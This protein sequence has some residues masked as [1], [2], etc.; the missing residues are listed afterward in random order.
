MN[1]ANV[2]QIAECMGVSKRTIQKRA[3]REKWPFDEYPVRGGMQRMYAIECLPEDVTIRLSRSFAVKA[4][5]KNGPSTIAQDE[6]TTT[7]I[8]RELSE[9]EFA[10][11]VAKYALLQ[12]ALRF[13]RASNTGKVEAIDEFV[14]RYTLHKVPVDDAVYREIPQ[15]SRASLLRWEKRFEYSGLLGL[16]DGFNVK[17]RRYDAHIKQALQQRFGELLTASPTCSVN[18]AFSY[19]SAIYPVSL[20]PSARQWEKLREQLLENILAASEDNAEQ[21]IWEMFVFP[22]GLRFTDVENVAIMITELQTGRHFFALVET[23]NIQVCDA[24]LRKALLHWNKPEG[25]KIVSGLLPVSYTSQALLRALGIRCWSNNRRYPMSQR[26]VELV[27]YL[28]FCL[29]QSVGSDDVQS[30]MNRVLFDLLQMTDVNR[31]QPTIIADKEDEQR[32]GEHINMP[33][34]DLPYVADEMHEKIAAQRSREDRVVAEPFAKD[35]FLEESS[36]AQS[37]QVSVRMLD[38]LLAALPEHG[39]LVKV[40]VHGITFENRLFTADWLVDYVGHVV[41]CRWDPIMTNQL[42]VFTALTKRFIGTV[43]YVKS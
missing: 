19:L 32:L 15:V 9:A 6:T 14:A 7:D 13:A 11:C 24:L 18:Q 25:V 33:M 30:L 31:H 35:C 38:G 16:L 4:G 12:A 42:F 37:W 8:E 21:P 22:V 39:G 29:C 27:R 36:P 10:R 3:L 1:Q 28:L 2:I 23:V 5:L 43:N 17:I 34:L 40:S 20:L 41:H 26:S